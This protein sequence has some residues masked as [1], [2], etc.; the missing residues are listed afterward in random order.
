MMVAEEGTQVEQIIQL[1]GGE[2]AVNGFSEFKPLTA[3]ALVA[4]IRMLFY[5]LI[6]ACRVWEALTCYWRC[7]ES[8]KARFGVE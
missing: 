3:E 4:A 7:R 6:V 1:A 2:N 8:L 5:S